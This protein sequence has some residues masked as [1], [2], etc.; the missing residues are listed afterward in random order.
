MIEFFNRLF[1]RHGSSATAKE[2]LRLVLLSDHL[3]LAPNLVDDLKRELVDVISRYVEVDKE[4]I[5]LNFEQREKVIAMLANVP[6]LSMHP[7]TRHNG[8]KRTTRRASDGTKRP[9][10]RRKRA[11]SSAGAANTPVPVGETTPSPAPE[12]PPAPAATPNSF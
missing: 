2:R 11:T 5:E 4:N 8:A 1:G 3:A 12:A 9:R 6:I 10:R 7:E